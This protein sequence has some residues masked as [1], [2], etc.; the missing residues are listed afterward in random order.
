MVMLLLY[1]LS[2][3]VCLNENRLNKEGCYKKLVTEYEFAKKI[4]YI[5]LPFFLLYIISLLSGKLLFDFANPQDTISQTANTLLIL[6]QAFLYFSIASLFAVTSALLRTMFLLASKN[7]HFYLARGCLDISKKLNKEGDKKPDNE[8][9]KMKYILKGL[10]FYNKYL[11]RNL[12]LQINRLENTF[13]NIMVESKVDRE[14][15]SSIYHV[16]EVK[17]KL[18]AIRHFS[19]YR[20]ESSEPF[21]VKNVAIE[22]IKEWSGILATLVSIMTGL[23]GIIVSLSS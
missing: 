20:K 12:G 8:T 15:K 5:L 18:Y 6:A 13:Y 17:D 2:S 4:I 23:Y 1:P 3:V 14:E 21:L 16:F 10:Y 19:Q 9:E 22:R 11:K 7:F